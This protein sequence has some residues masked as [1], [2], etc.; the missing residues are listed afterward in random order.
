[1][2]LDLLRLQLDELWPAGAGL[3]RELM[4]TSDLSRED[5]RVS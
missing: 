5:Y 4:G 3:A 2:A 1:M